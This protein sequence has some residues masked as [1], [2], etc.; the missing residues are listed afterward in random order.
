MFHLVT[1]VED[2]IHL[3]PEEIMAQVIELDEDLLQPV[4]CSLEINC[5]GIKIIVE[6]KD[7]CLIHEPNIMFQRKF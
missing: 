1:Y 2:E 4:Q 5:D 3:E 7:V 6:N